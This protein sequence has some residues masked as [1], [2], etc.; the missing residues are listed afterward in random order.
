VGWELEAR[1]RRD[2]VGVEGKKGCREGV[3]GMGTDE[4]RRYIRA[5]SG[6]SKRVTISG[7]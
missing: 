6:A 1:T 7:T 2:E 5:V 3:S 4:E